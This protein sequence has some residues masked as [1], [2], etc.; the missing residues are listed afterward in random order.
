MVYEYQEVA[1]RVSHLLHSPLDLKLLPPPPLLERER[2]HRCLPT[3]RS[4]RANASEEA[5]DCKDEDRAIQ[6]SDGEEAIWKGKR[7][8]P[9]SCRY[10]GSAAVAQDCCLEEVQVSE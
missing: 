1:P 6:G 3:P 5:H 9:R 4:P 8:V 10:D 7:E 2:L